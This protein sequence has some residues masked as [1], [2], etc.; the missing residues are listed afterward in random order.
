MYN[1]PQQP[2]EQTIDTPVIWDAIA[3][4]VTSM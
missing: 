4:I 3:L 1:A 2:V